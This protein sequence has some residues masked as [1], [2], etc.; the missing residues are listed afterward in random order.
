MHRYR[1]ADSHALEL[2]FLE[3]GIDP[4]SVE[5]HHGQERR[6][7]GDAL[8]DL[9]GAFGDHAA[10]RRGELG[11]M[12]GERGIAHRGGGGQHLRMVRNGGAVDLR[13]GLTQLLARGRD[14]G[15]RG[16]DGI[17]RMRQLFGRD[18]AVRDEAAA[19]LQILI[20]GACR[21]FPLLDLCAQL[22]ALREEAAHLAHG[23]RE[24]GFRIGLGDLRVGR[25]ELQHGL[26]DGDALRVIH[27]QTDHRAGYFTGDLHH[28]A[29][30][31]GIIG[32]FIVAAV[33]EPIRRIAHTAQQHHGGQADERSAACPAGRRRLAGPVGLAGSGACRSIGGH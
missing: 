22:L 28:I 14:I 29:V 13:H 12:Q 24:V 32:G 20:G 26:P 27:V 15:A 17:A 16:S 11:A 19:P 10:D 33:Q 8:A 2:S 31:I 21:L 5:R 7:R 18:G 30:D 4:H 9:H 6:T 3:V 23:A 25:I 1:L